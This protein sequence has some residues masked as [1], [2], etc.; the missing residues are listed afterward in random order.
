M[1]THVFLTTRKQRTGTLV[2]NFEESC[3]STVFAATCYCPSSHCISTQKT[4]SLSANLNR[5]R[6][7]WVSES[8]KGLPC[9]RSSSYSAYELDRQSQPRRRCH[10]WKLQDQ[11]FAFLGQFGSGCIS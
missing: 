11:P 6:S 10:C 7:Q 9:L 2:K 5:N 3:E 4:L 1:S 8:V